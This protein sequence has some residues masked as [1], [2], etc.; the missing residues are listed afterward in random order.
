MQAA[1]K[2]DLSVFKHFSLDSKLWVF[3]ANQTLNDEQFNSLETTLSDFCTSW[4]SHGAAL[5]ADFCILERL[6][7]L[8]SVDSS[9]K[10]A[11]GC[12]IDTLTKTMLELERTLSVKFTDRLC[13]ATELEENVTL[14]AYSDLIKEV[15]SKKL[16][17]QTLIFNNSIASLGQLKE[18]KQPI[19]HSWISNQ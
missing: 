3:Q 6:F 7:V 13:I 9:D 19:Y 16:P 17:E 1:T 14:W 11:S 10:N 18:W 8:V 2:N 4:S 12:S 5:K 15:Q